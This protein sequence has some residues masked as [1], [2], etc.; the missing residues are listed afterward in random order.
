MGSKKEKFSARTRKVKVEKEL[1]PVW[2]FYI[3]TR[4]IPYYAKYGLSVTFAPITNRS[5]RGCNDLRKPMD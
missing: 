2:I 3:F 5:A 1:A 4:L